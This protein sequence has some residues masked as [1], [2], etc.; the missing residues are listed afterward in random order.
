MKIFADRRKARSSK[1][2]KQI[3]SEKIEASFVDAAA[4]RDGKAFAVSVED[5]LGK[6]FNCAS[7]RTTD[8][9]VAEQV[10]TALAMQDGR[11]D[12]HSD[13]FGHY[14]RSVDI[15]GGRD[16]YRIQAFQKGRVAR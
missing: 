8:P 7:I 1:I 13:S 10:V 16:V 2:L 12:V 6:F 5:T 14:K 4:Y 15:L 11:R 3:T 9:E